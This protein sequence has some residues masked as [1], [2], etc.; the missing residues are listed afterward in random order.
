MGKQAKL[1]AMRKEQRKAAIQKLWALYLTLP[2]IECK[3]K[4]HE[5]CGPI[6]IGDIEA[7]NIHALYSI[8]PR[9][10][11]GRLSNGFRAMTTSEG[12]CPLLK[13]GKCSVYDAR[14]IICRLYGVVEKMQCE[15]GCKPTSWVSDD[16]SI[17][18]I[19]EV[20][21]LCDQL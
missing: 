2:T 1:K 20:Q 14:P 18:L 8:R 7:K 4:C 12:N 6:P 15:H 21:D 5:A 11:D 9:V 16:E 17:R 3:K 13:D 19:Q 10:S